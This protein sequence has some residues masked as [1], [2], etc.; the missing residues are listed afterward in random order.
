MRT[1]NIVTVVLG[2]CF[3]GIVFGMSQCN[4]QQNEVEKMRLSSGVTRKQMSLEKG[5]YGIDTTC[6]DVNK[7]NAA[8]ALICIEYYRNRN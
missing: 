2:I 7:D 6:A 1:E 5:E 3:L 8:Q 4:L